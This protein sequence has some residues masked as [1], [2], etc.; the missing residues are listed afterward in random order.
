[1]LPYVYHRWRE[2]SGAP[3]V[4]K[5]IMISTS[6]HR[7]AQLGFPYYLSTGEGFIQSTA[8]SHVWTIRVW[9]FSGAHVYACVT[10]EANQG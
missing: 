9:S 10:S 8:L 7:I 4:H 5:A 6:I 1:M 3:V 2:I